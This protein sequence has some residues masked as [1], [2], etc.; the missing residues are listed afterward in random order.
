MNE[1]TVRKSVKSAA[2]CE[3]SSPFAAAAAAD[4][5]R[6]E[7]CNKGKVYLV[8][9]GPGDPELL[10]LK[11]RRLIE[12]CDV[13]VFDRLV[14]K[15]IM[16]MIPEGRELIDVGKNVGDHPVPQHEINEI[17]LR[18]ALEGK[19]V[20]RLKGG[21]PFVFGRGGEE[22]ELLADNGV[23]FEE[24]PGITSSIAVPAYAGIPVTHRDFCSSFHIITGHAKAGSEVSIDFDALVRLS[25]TLIFMMS[26]STVGMISSGLKQAGM[27][28]E[29]PCAVI[30]NGTGPNQRSFVSNLN[31]IEKTVYDN[32]IKSP[33]VIVVGRVCSL[34]DRFNWFEKL[35]LS[36]LSIVVTQPE[37]KASK[38]EAM[39]RKLGADTKLYP[40]IKTEYI[41]P[42]APE[43][44]GRDVL[45]FTSAE[46]VNSFFE[47]LLGE[48]KDARYLS[49]KKIAC[50]GP[51][52]AGA[53]RA[54]GINCDFMPKEYY[55][56]NLAEEM[57]ST[58]FITGDS[59]LLLLRAKI[60]SAEIT[61]I[62]SENSVDFTDYPV[63]TTSLICRDEKIDGEDFDYVSF[64]SRSCVEG[65]AKTCGIKDMSSVKALCIG[66][67]TAEL[68]ASYG[69]NVIVSDEATIISM[70]DKIV[71]EAKNE[72]RKTT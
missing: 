21:D 25:G 53:L 9:A 11:G 1:K 50:I 8:G 34:A 68:A 16:D 17:L 57:I 52:T 27:D 66:Q 55:G 69:M 29:M 39:L 24:V 23:E 31:N 62:L 46:G 45:V 13:I 18:E 7:S 30:E 32:S 49:G 56:R 37:K 47:W 33:A 35:P 4:S 71:E 12:E 19:Q 14:G 65:F 48:G 42:L 58:G 59:S 28:G 26:V 10:T 5:Q 70:V 43:L 40:C 2:S 51:A 61:D 64:T 63:Y 38:L 44:E 60:G 22:L 36:G 15:K 20:L 6:G 54:F 3:K 41:R 72:Q 67:K